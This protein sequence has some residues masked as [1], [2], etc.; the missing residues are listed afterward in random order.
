MMDV[1][2]GS[3]GSGGGGFGQLTRFEE[4]RTRAQALTG[5]SR[6]ELRERLEASDLEQVALEFESLFASM[7]V[8]EM[9]KTLSEGLF[10][11]G[12][13]ADT[14]AG[15]FDEH[16]G[17]ELAETGALDLV[18]ILRAGLPQGDVEAAEGDGR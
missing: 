7:L 5:E 10:G 9:R 17:R 11:E 2:L 4:A 12:P 3:I 13:G 8:K 18:G 1:N 15:W 14:Y 16:V 6:A